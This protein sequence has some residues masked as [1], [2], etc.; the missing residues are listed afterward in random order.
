[1]TKRAKPKSKVS[2]A[3]ML[4]A[5]QAAN[6][7]AER[8][9]ADEVH[10]LYVSSK[11]RLQLMLLLLAGILVW[12]TL[13]VAHIQKKYRGFLQFLKRGACLDY[14]AF[15]YNTLHYATALSIPGSVSEVK[16]TYPVQ[17]LIPAWWPP[18]PMLPSFTEA[19]PFWIALAIEYP[20]LSII[21][22]SNSAFPQ[23]VKRAYH[24]SCFMCVMQKVDGPH[25]GAT[26]IPKMFDISNMCSYK[27][28]AGKCGADQIIC[29]AFRAIYF[30]RQQS[31]PQCTLNPTFPAE[32]LGNCQLRNFGPLQISSSAQNESAIGGGVGWGFAGHT[33]GSTLTSAASQGSAG[34]K[35]A[36]AVANIA[37]TAAFAIG[38]AAIAAA[39]YRQKIKAGRKEC[40]EALYAQMC[41]N[42]TNYCRYDPKKDASG[43]FLGSVAGVL[44]VGNEEE[45]G[46]VGEET[47]RWSVG[48]ELGSNCLVYDRN[49]P[50][51]NLVGGG[52]DDKAVA[53][54]LWQRCCNP[55]RPH[56]EPPQL[57]PPMESGQPHPVNSCMPQHCL[58]PNSDVEQCFNGRGYTPNPKT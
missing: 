29:D 11:R 19:S 2:D 30:A 23:A 35:A 58:G 34:V 32:C 45:E 37:V 57:R 5:L 53:G 25:A 27:A 31:Y 13:K 56:T 48:S 17:T 46:D 54:Q 9:M 38:G 44:G 10:H 3:K 40:D 33:V 6:M 21:K 43:G 26:H 28:S 7:I 51:P 22:F 47:S 20:I 8:Q 41:S 36:G 49:S 12:I 4:E 18:G 55:L 24:S 39:L 42:K 14:K 1:M 16:D 50:R 52:F 15:G